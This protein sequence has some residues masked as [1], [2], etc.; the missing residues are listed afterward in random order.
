[1]IISHTHQFIFTKPRK[2]AGSSV[3]VA[4]AQQCGADDI[5][6]PVL[7]DKSIDAE[8]INDYARNYQGYFNHLRPFRIRQKIGRTLWNE[9]F[10]FT[11]V[12]NPWDMLVSRYF[13]SKQVVQKT[14][15]QIVEE[16]K[17]EPLNIDKWGK[18][19]IACDRHIRHKVVTPD[20]DFRAFIKKLHGNFSNTKYYFD[21]KGK[22]WNDF[23][24]RYENLEEDYKTVCKKIGIPYEPLPG[25]KT[26]VRESRNYS[27]M[28]DDES[29]KIV[30]KLFK[31]EIEYFHYTFGE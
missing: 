4:L 27:T 20:D 18:L 23:V 7:L 30:A 21:W 3:Q 5:I 6:T 17:K 16:V 12:R 2:V 29:R 28:Y 8:Q 15:K 22:P 14:P 24:M 1:M 9:Y 19:S 13:W 10:K 26:K 25:L 11:I 31:K